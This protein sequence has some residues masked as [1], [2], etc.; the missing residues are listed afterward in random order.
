MCLCY[1]YS[2]P[3]YRRL[4]TYVVQKTIPKPTKR[5]RDQHD[6]PE[7]PAKRTARP[8]ISTALP[9]P[10]NDTRYVIGWLV[11]WLVGWCLLINATDSITKHVAMDCEMVGVGYR[12]QE[13]M[14][15]QVVIVNESGSV[16]YQTY[17]APVE[18]VIDYRTHVSGI[19]PHHLVGGMLL[20]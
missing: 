9:E 6:E 18:N 11:G 10:G 8:E 4:N 3:A 5:K 13:S 19:Q 16:I 20:V 14:L 17:V 1:R 12:G 2:V 7:V 15:A